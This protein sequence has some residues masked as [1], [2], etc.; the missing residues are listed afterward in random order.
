MNWHNISTLECGPFGSNRDPVYTH[1]PIATTICTT[2]LSYLTK[3]FYDHEHEY[4]SRYWLTKS[5]CKIKFA[6]TYKLLKNLI[7]NRYEISNNNIER[8]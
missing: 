5:T 8:K 4:I 3:Q 1:I 2:Q 7:F 6:L